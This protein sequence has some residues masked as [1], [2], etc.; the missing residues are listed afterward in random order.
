M[1]IRD[2]Y[3]SHGEYRGHC[4]ICYDNCPAGMESPSNIGFVKIREAGIGHE[5][6]EKAAEISRAVL[7]S[8]SYLRR[9][10]EALH[11]RRR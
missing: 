10:A 11:H 3:A 5:A 1:G 9:Q 6:P 2:Y 8:E 4:G 7:S